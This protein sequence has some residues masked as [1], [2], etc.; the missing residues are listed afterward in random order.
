M[1][2]MT[3]PTDRV[4]FIFDYTTNSHNSLKTVL[5]LDNKNYFDRISIYTEVFNYDTTTV[6]LENSNIYFL[7]FFDLDN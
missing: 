7:I 2:N 1:A 6:L 3:D 4:L 5:K